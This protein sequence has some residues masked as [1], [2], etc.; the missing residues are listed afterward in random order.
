MSQPL[1]WGI[2][3]TAKINDRLLPAFSAST[4][5]EVVAVASRD[6]EK[7]AAYAKEKG[8]PKSYGSYEALLADA[9]IDVVYI[10]LPNH[11]HDEWTRKA[12]D[13]G[14][15]IL[16]EKPLT[17]TAP[18]AE[19][20]IAYCRSKGVRLMDGF[21]WPHHPRT[22]KIREV[23]DSGTIGTVQKVV[24]AFTFNLEGLPTSNIRMQPQAGGGGLLDVGCYTTYAIRWWMGAEPV[25]VFATA[26]FVNGVDVGMCG[27]WT[28]A[29]GRTATFDCGFTHPLRTQV[30]IVGTKAVIRIPNMWIPDDQAVFEIHRQNGDFD[31][32]IETIATPGHNQMVHMIDDFAAAV[33]GLQECTP[34]PDQAV[35]TGRVMDALAKS[36]KTGLEV[37]L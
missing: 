24:A 28:F 26:K 36:A 37:T 18:E 8:I 4:T 7:A 9:S 35:L 21:M 27:V 6:A 17:V 1:R 2:L 16:C 33:R 10:P 30:E 19:S 34:N 12:A 29:D 20:L 23:I 32:G 22:A 25:K 13:A 3:S 15:H 14:K 31:A 11:M 5:A